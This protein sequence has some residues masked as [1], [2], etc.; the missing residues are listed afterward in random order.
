MLDLVWA[1]ASLPPRAAPAGAAPGQVVLGAEGDFPCAARAH[2]RPDPA[3]S[4]PSARPKCAFALSGSRTVRASNRS[5]APPGSRRSRIPCPR[6]GPLPAADPE[7]GEEPGSCGRPCRRSALRSVILWPV[8]FRTSNRRCGRRRPIGCARARRLRVVKLQI[9]AGESTC[10]DRA[11]R[12]WTPCSSPAHLLAERRERA[13]SRHCWACWASPGEGADFGLH[14]RDRARVP[15]AA[16]LPVSAPDGAS[17]DSVNGRP[18]L[19][20][21]RC[22]RLLRRRMGTGE[23]RDR[24]PAECFTAVAPR[25]R[26]RACSDG[27]VLQ[28]HL[29]RGASDG[30]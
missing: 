14:A 18:G 30:S 21:R 10:S 9:A 20:G 26:R 27:V 24:Q 4:P 17:T 5:S 15:L 12:R 3:R 2:T 29:A 8:T 19:R 7:G 25:G 23:Q 1:A 13:C 16:H 6:A 22:R 11:E 28:P